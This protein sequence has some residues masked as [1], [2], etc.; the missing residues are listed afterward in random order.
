MSW[1][2]VSD[3]EL[4]AASVRERSA[5]GVFYE[6]HERAVPGFFGAVTHRP[7]LAADLTAE[8][9][10]AA[11]DSVVLRPRHIELVEALVAAEGERDRRSVAGGAAAGPGD[12]TARAGCST[13]APTVRVSF[14]A[15][16]AI[17]S[18]SEMYLL[19]ARFPAS[20]L[21]RCRRVVLFVPSQ[22]NIRRGERVE[23]AGTVP[24]DCRARLV[25][26]VLLA[27][28]SYH[29]GKPP[30]AAVGRFTRALPS[31]GIARRP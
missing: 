24:H 1:T 23:L 2:A 7:E 12:G 20:P 27:D 26:S 19:E 17:T 18:A 9:F 31:Q 6:R 21:Q 16:V 29:N 3:E 14:K 11:L 22:R 28:I 4:L 8:T 30:A 15:P 13:S 5:F 10:A 25:A